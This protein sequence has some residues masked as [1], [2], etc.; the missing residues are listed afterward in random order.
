MLQH[1]WRDHLLC[2]RGRLLPEDRLMW[3][4]VAKLCSARG[5]KEAAR[6]QSPQAWP[7]GDSMWPPKEMGHKH[8]KDLLVWPNLASPC[9]GANEPECLDVPDSL[10][11]CLRLVF[12]YLFGLY[13]W[14]LVHQVGG[15]VGWE[16]ARNVLEDGVGGV[17]SPLC[18][19][20]L[21]CEH[22]T[23]DSSSGLC[24]SFLAQIEG[25]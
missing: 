20:H 8:C 16:G 18:F 21:H 3:L 4:L 6:L 7:C 5:W 12:L 22:N 19:L 23:D 13:S 9:V 15:S 11:M 24:A 14:A 10:N 25:K 1:L 2:N 17:L